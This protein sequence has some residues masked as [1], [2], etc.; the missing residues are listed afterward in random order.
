MVAKTI[1]HDDPIAKM[2]LRSQLQMKA[3]S[4]GLGV[5]ATDEFS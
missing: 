3:S 5:P 2:V 4:V 1:R